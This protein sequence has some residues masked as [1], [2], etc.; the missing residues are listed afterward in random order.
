MLHILLLILQIILWIVLGLLG[1]ILFL[2]LLVLFAPIKYKAAASFDENIKADVKISFLI[3]SVY[4]LYDKQ[5][6]VLDQIIR[7]CGI[8]FGGSNKTAK[9]KNKKAK[10]NK[11]IMES[12]GLNADTDD[13]DDF[14]DYF[15]DDDSENALDDRQSE[16]NSE[17]IEDT[18]DNNVDIATGST[19]HA[20]VDNIGNVNNEN[21]SNTAEHTDE[22]DEA[23]EDDRQDSE[24]K[25]KK[26]KKTKKKVDINSATQKL[27]AAKKKLER[28][29]KVW[30]ASCTV[31]TRAYL[32]KYFPSI[33]KHISPRKITGR[34]RYGMKEPYKTGMATGYLSMMPF[35]YQK[36]FYFEPDFH[37]KIIEGNVKLK[38]FLQLG[39]ILRIAL[40]INIWRTIK[41]FKR[42]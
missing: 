7:I 6:D 39:Y 14:V 34:L 28:F 41:L 33:L 18:T 3:V 29:K 9:A 30:D 13:S 31:K 19:D 10:K 32:K 36:G 38:G 35:A 11:E 25:S 4:I 16:T 37:N 26:E 2:V 5:K 27:E 15:D 23:V 42:I 12:E 24:E 22:A 8:R 40:N 20:S 21:T 17:N 1:L